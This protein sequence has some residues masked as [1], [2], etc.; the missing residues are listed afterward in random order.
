MKGK[1]FVGRQRELQLIEHFI[2]SPSPG[3][4]VVYGRRRI[5]KTTLLEQATKNRTS[6]RIE[7]VEGRSRKQQ[8]EAFLFQLHR[9]IHENSL[10][11]V[12][13]KAANWMEAFAL[14]ADI[15]REL[16][17][18]QSKV[19]VL[20]EFQWMA[21]YRADVV[22]DLKMVWDAYLSKIP[23]M[24][25]VLCGSIA[26][27]MYGKVIR[28]KALYGRIEQSI[29]LQAME[30]GETAQL[31]P[32]SGFDEV[33]L[34]QMLY[35][36][37]PEYI[38]LAAKEPSVALSP[39]TLA[40]SRGGFLFDEYDRIFISHF[41]KNDDFQK[42]V[43]ILSAHPNGLTRPEVVS[44]L[45]LDHG[46]TTSSHLADLESAGFIHSWQRPDKPGAKTKKLY[47]LSDAYLRFFFAFV[48]KRRAEIRDG[49]PE[50]IYGDIRNSG[51]W[52]AW[53]GTAF[54]AV[55]LQHRKKIAQ[56]LGF[57][58]IRYH[59]GPFFE[60]GENASQ[61]D[62]L[63]DRDDKVFTLCEA[64]HQ[65]T[66]VGKTIIQEVERKAQ[67]LVTLYPKRSVHRVLLV[68]GDVSG[69][70]ERSGYFYRIIRAEELA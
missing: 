34:A 57:S 1:S 36:G 29:H 45:G 50:V 7:G 18:D 14:L 62:L 33:L 26:S 10:P 70:V 53:A 40:F 16:P 5:G 2:A 41:G 28:S 38:R 69:E 24:K 58:G 61:I 43:E 67:R 51:A 48:H 13:E 27:F 20:D 64:K 54:E 56:L 63:F 32:Q 4:C 11:E 60:A 30:L 68:S 44:K 55:C 22:G 3:I 59:S 21:N 19:I 46:K 23:G 49:D 9:H 52:H 12:S 47:V 66:P 65:I 25:L 35:G 39:A 42:I 37:V 31:L 8:I 17:D 15:F 6:L